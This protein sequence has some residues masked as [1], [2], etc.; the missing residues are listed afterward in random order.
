MNS[1]LA[2]AWEV[3][4]VMQQWAWT[5]L[6]WFLMVMG[7]ATLLALIVGIGVGK[8]FSNKGISGAEGDK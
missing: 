5:G 3:L 7:A 8:Y 4:L 1:T 6:R 2:K